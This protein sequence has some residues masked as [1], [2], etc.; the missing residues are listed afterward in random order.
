[1]PYTLATIWEVLRMSF[2]V[3]SFGHVAIKDITIKGYHV[4][5]SSEVLA[6]FYATTTNPEVWPEPEKFKPQRFISADGEL[7]G[8]SNIFSFSLGK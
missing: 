8:T 7:T 2:P 3:T 5:K 1:M 6:N 4:P